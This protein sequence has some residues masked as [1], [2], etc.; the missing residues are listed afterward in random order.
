MEYNKLNVKIIIILAV[1][2]IFASFRP[3]MVENPENEQI[4]RI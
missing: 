1:L 2:A 3:N 4:Q